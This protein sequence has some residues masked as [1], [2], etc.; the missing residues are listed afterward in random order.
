MEEVQK[1]IGEKR[2]GGGLFGIEEKM[3]KVDF[4]FQECEKAFLTEMRRTEHL[5]DR[6]ERYIAV[7][8]VVVGFK[9]VDIDNHALSGTHSQGLVNFLAIAGFV[10]LGISLIQAIISRRV[11]GYLSYPRGDV[12][13]E[14]LKPDEINCD[15]AKIK[16]AK[17]YLNARECNAVINDG[18][19]KTL[20]LCG[21][22]IVAGFS[23]AALGHL[24]SKFW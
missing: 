23:L 1:V 19:A 24:I 5:T 12:L 4:V 6:A 9:F 7:I 20:S 13:I 18:R 2:C 10:I 8:V 16:V 14:E 3:K 17:M 21:V 15:M 22:F 11:F